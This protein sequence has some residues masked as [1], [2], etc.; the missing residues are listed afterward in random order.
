MLNIPIFPVLIYEPKN[1]LP[2]TTGGQKPDYKERYSGP[3]ADGDI[4]V[5]YES[6]QP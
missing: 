5:M 4:F 2:S 6:M 1:L 3:P